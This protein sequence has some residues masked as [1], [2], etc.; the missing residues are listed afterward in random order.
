[1]FIADKNPPSPKKLL[2]LT[3]Q[4]L[5]WQTENK[6]HPDLEQADPHLKQAVS[7]ISNLLTLPLRNDS[8][9]RKE[10][11]QEKS[12][13]QQ[14]IKQ[15]R[16]QLQSTST[17]FRNIIDKNADAIIILDTQGKI[18]FVNPTAESLF[19]SPAEQLISRDLFGELV[20]ERPG[21]MNTGTIKRAK[22]R[23]ETRVVQTQVD[24][25]RPDQQIAIAE[26]RIVETEWEGKLAFLA[27]LRDITEREQ[28]EIALRSREAEL[29][30]K[31][32]ELEKTLGELKKTQA[33]L[34]QTEKM[35]SLGQLVAGVAHEINNPINFITGNLVHANHYATDLLKLL[36]LYEKHYPNPAMEIK[37]LREEADI[38]FLGED[39]PKLLDS[40]KV[41]GERIQKIV[42]SLRNFSRH[43]Q[44]EIKP[45]NIHEGIDNTLMILQHRLKERPNA[46]I[47]VLKEY[48]QLPR[49]ECCAGEL[50]QVFMNIICNAIDALENQPH[51][52]ITI[53]TELKNN[54]GNSAKP[55]SVVIRICD[56][57]K[58][59]PLEEQT[60][61]FDPFFTTKPVGSGTGLGLSISYQVIVEKHGG[62]LKCISQ[63]GQGAEFWI[64]IPVT[65]SLKPEPA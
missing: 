38:I 13:L 61:L 46:E 52:Q 21:Q 47:K 65:N 43:D 60:Q 35:S 22:A 9:K 34:V 36:K 12:E 25:N 7:Y 40:M 23:Q 28:A 62:I 3:E 1:M 41:G 44:A 64:E 15:L 53:S 63:P 14:E 55:P 19:N 24:V 6:D 27:T 58:G 33:Q 11:V 2:N 56:N 17:A 16:H 42:L 37:Q 39:F 51:P 32:K 49:V 10:W 20:R 29:C 48:S 30:S 8:L 59:I 54:T 4:C 5:S 45:V 50:N 26:I 57:G 31:T 18:R